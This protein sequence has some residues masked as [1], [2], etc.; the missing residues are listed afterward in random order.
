MNQTAF[1]R[2]AA[3]FAAFRPPYAE[4]ALARL[5]TWEGMSPAWTVADVGAGTGHLTRH[6]VGHFRH[7]YAVEPDD[8][9]RA[10]CIRNLGRA[11]GFAALA[12]AAEAI[13]LPTG[14]VNLITVGQ[15]LHW[16][17]AVLTQAE[18]ARLL[19][20]PGHLAVIWNRYDGYVDPVLDGYF[21]ND[22]SRQE[23]EWPMRIQET[24][25]QFLGGSRSAAASPHPGEP[26]YAAFEERLR[27]VFQARARDGLIEINYTT[28]LVTGRLARTT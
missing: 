26:G 28:V 14:S 20:P 13:P 2:K 19:A 16:F 11:P 5:Y 24:W 21:A 27:H 8:A 12:A 25:A 22:G 6:L 23:R 15:A 3:D 10:A 4:G 18:F 9:M 17:D 7:V 1:A